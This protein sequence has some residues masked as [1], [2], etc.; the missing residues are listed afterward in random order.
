MHMHKM[1][2]CL[3]QRLAV[4]HVTPTARHRRCIYPPLLKKSRRSQLA[5]FTFAQIFI[6]FGIWGGHQI[7]EKSARRKHVRLQLTL[8][9]H[10]KVKHDGFSP[11]HG[12]YFIGLSSSKYDDGRRHRCH[13]HTDPLVAPPPPAPSQARPPNKHTRRAVSQ[14]SSN[15]R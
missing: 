6:N 7:R 12:R 13:R 9:K 8:V 1:V 10:L 2:R 3:G 14:Q 4:P 11:G 15:L 5:G